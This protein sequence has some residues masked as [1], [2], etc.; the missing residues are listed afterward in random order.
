MPSQEIKDKLCAKIERL[1]KYVKKSQY[2]ISIDSFYQE[3]IEEMIKL[4]DE[5]DE[6]MEKLVEYYLSV[7]K[8]ILG[9]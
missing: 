2:K 5:A 7:E 1:D 8:R 4:V 6:A 9:D 3:E